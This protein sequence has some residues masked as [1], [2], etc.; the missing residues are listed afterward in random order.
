VESKPTSTEGLESH[1][2]RRTTHFYFKRTLGSFS[3]EKSFQD[4]NW[5]SIRFVFASSS[6]NPLNL[7]WEFFVQLSN[8]ALLEDFF[9]VSYQDWN[10]VLCESFGVKKPV[11]NHSLVHL[12]LGTV[13]QSSSL[14]FG[15]ISKVK[16]TFVATLRLD[17]PT[18]LWDFLCL[19]LFFGFISP[20]FKRHNWATAADLLL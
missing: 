16:S 14:F 2:V 13:H 3:I 20:H 9:V 15:N 19:F 11:G 8:E 6:R 12:K 1:S 18:S 10:G 7:L 4:I 5:W 17:F